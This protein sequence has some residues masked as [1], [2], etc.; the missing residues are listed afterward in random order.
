MIWFFEVVIKEYCIFEVEHVCPCKIFSTPFCHQN[1]NISSSLGTKHM[2]FCHLLIDSMWKPTFQRS[3]KPL[4]WAHYGRWYWYSVMANASA[5]SLAVVASTDLA[6]SFTKQHGFS[7]RIIKFQPF[8][9]IL[10]ESTHQFYPPMITYELC[11]VVLYHPTLD[12]AVCFWR[13][14][15]A[16]GR[17]PSQR[18]AKAEKFSSH[19]RAFG[20]CALSIQI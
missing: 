12:G 18:C 2:S 3:F 8:S 19:L 14:R 5:Q 13:L 10:I 1:L 16:A 6:V 7:A 11:I 9:I 4:L 20:R 17:N 15:E